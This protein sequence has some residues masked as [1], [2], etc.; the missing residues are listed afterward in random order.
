MN[1]RTTVCDG[2]KRTVEP[3]QFFLSLY[4]DRDQEDD[5]PLPQQITVEGLT[6]AI[7]PKR[8]RGDRKGPACTAEVDLCM[9]CA[10]NPISLLG[11][12]VTWQS[13]EEGG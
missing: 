8:R 12:S 11:L 5:R 1:V 9:Q 6:F 13:N 3:G 2:C 7:A 4:I 10:E